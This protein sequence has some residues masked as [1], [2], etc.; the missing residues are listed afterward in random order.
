[1]EI[2]GVAH[3]ID[4]GATTPPART[5][6]APVAHLLPNYDE[7]FIGHCE[8]GAM[9]ARLRAA[10]QDIENVALSGHLVA[11][12]GQV[13]GFWSRATR[14]QATVVETTPLVDLSPRERKAVAAAA[15]ALAAHLEQP[16]TVAKPTA[17]ATWQ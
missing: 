5:A 12:D 6:G 13:V 11:I 17:G 9:L 15:Q 7:Y 10:G 2:D 8:R 4:A 3:W 16:V 14:A 1:V